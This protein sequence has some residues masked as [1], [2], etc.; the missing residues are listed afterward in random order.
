VSQST[1]LYVDDEPALCRAFER[2]LR[3][4]LRVV[5]T[6]SALEALELM[7]RDRFDVVASDFRMPDASGLEVLRAARARIPGARRLLI[8]GRL[9]EDGETIAI[10]EDEVDGI[11]MKPW[12]LDELRRMVHRAALLATVARE[13][14]TLLEDA[15]LHRLF[16]SALELADPGAVR[17]AHLVVSLARAVAPA[18]GRAADVLPTI[19]TYLAHREAG[20]PCEEALA[21]LAESGVEPEVLGALGHAAP[22]VHGPT[23]GSGSRS[24]KAPPGPVAASASGSPAAGHAT[25]KARTLTPACPPPDAKTIV[26]RR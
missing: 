24:S 7:G 21:A 11:L 5:T 15:A 14:A 9:G 18:P 20:S 3:G 16:V 8:S 23:P 4:R 17:R 2:A 26:P 10:E 13:R 6:T 19:H 1:V 12:S 22:A 25:Q